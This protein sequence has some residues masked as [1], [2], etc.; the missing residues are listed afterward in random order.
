MTKQRAL[1][2]GERIMYVNKQQP[3]NCLFTVSIRGALSL[4]ILTKALDKLQKRHPLL[5]STISEDEYQPYFILKKDIEPIPIV[6][7]SRDD[8]NHWKTISKAQWHTYLDVGKGP[9]AKLVWVKGNEISELIL[10]CPHCIA[11]GVSMTTLLRELL[12]LIDNLEYELEDQLFIEDL[13]CPLKLSGWGKINLALKG[14]LGKCLARFF[15]PNKVNVAKILKPEASY[16]VHYRLNERDTK[17]ILSLCKLQEASLYTIVGACLLKAYQNLFPE[18]FKGKLI[19]PVD[20][21]KFLTNL[22]EDQLFAFAPI[23]ELG[24][25]KK[26]ENSI[27]HIAK[28]MKNDINKGINKINIAEILKMSEEFQSMVPK[29]MNH[30]LTKDGTHD[31]TF[32]NMGSLRIQEVFKTFEV[33]AI[34]SPTVSFPWRNPNTIV[35]SSYKGI[36]DLTFMSNEAVLTEDEAN[37]F[38]KTTFNLLT[39]TTSDSL[40][41]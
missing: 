35:I 30:L 11:D 22:K 17:K 31:F 16:M 7:F 12:L 28:E 40:K 33:I 2:A 20:I 26:D 8:E 19:C 25:N 9:L 34:Y 5:R 27:W 21:R 24:I 10:I 3:I 23:I 18:K 38:I 29:L 37:V 41:N 6:Q 13:S 15:L 14:Y 36:L 39:S 4:Q 32:S 1:S